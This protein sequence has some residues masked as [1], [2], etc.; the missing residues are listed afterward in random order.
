[1]PKLLVLMWY[2]PEGGFAG[3]FVR[4]ERILEELAGF[5]VSVITTDSTTWR[6]SHPSIGVFAIP[7]RRL[8]CKRGILFVLFRLLNWVGFTI[9]AIA[10][11]FLRDRDS[12]IVYV[13]YSELPHMTAAGLIIAK[14]L[15]RP[16][17]LCNLNVRG[18]SAWPLN[19]WL[20]NK[21]DMIITLSRALST[22]LAYAGVR[23]RIELGG[24]GVDD[25]HIAPM[26]IPRYDAVF[27]GRH[28]AEKGVYDLLEI[29]RR[30]NN[31]RN[32]LRLAMAGPVRDDIKIDLLARVQSFGLAG[33][34]DIL[35]PV[36][37][38]EK[39]RL[40]AS[41][42]CCAFPSRVEGWG[43]V[44]IEAHFAGL[45]VVAY[46]LPAYTENI[47]SSPAAELVPVGDYD[48][49]AARLIETLVQDE[50]TS[51]STAREWARRF[52]WQAAAE[53]ERALLIR[54]L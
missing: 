14:I 32:G 49:F 51:I 31:E 42:R 11:A 53:T 16:L 19:R 24:V 39:W 25:R 54:L 8:Y 35:G 48:A 43:I 29:W 38:D 46:N 26:R 27:I 22:E 5:D 44:P 50:E 33:L 12:S 3:G 10:R 18:T 9:F 13:P 15:R 34:V 30:C 23:G 40:Y 47:V 21:A 4:A 37:E 6:P 41:A 36:S 1:M 7:L 2:P 52:S 45:K 17:V 28:T 20:H